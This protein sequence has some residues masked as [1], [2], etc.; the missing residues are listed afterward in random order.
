MGKPRKKIHNCLFFLRDPLLESSAGPGHL[1]SGVNQCG[2]F[3]QHFS[4]GKKTS[5]MLVLVSEVIFD[6][7]GDRYGDLGWL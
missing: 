5:V 6:G 3:G 4:V 1:E 7:N 2:K